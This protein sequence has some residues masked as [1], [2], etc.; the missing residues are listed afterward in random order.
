VLGAGTMGAA[1]A[2]HAANAGLSVDLLDIAPEA[3]TSEEESGGLSLD[4]PA[5]RNRIVNAGFERMRR[6]KPPALLSDGVAAR[7]RLGNFADDLQRL[8]EADW[9]LEAV[10]EDLA[11][12]RALLEGVEAA[13]GDSAIV[14][15]NTSGIPLSRIVE[16]RSPAFRIRFLGTHFFNPP[17]YM[18]LLEVIPTGDTD[19]DLVEYMRSFCQRVLDKRV[20]IAKDTPNFIANRI[21]SYSGMHTV[22]Y[23]LD[24]GYS[25]EEVDALTGPLIGRPKSATFRLTDVVGLDIKLMVAENLYRLVPHDESRDDLEAPEA[26]RRMRAAGLLGNKT[27]SGFYRR[28]ERDGK[29]VFDVL[30]L[31]SLTYRPARQHEDGT[32]AEAARRKDPGERLRFL[33]GKAETDRSAR[34]VRDTLL[35]VLAYAARRI[36]EIADSPA[37]ID[38]AMEWGYGHESGPFRTWDLLGVSRTAEEMEAIGIAVAPWVRAMLSDGNTSFYRQG[39]RVVYGPG[40]QEYEPV[41]EDPPATDLGRPGG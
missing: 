41:R 14:S 19:P 39:G 24:N 22:R 26:L 36:P 12:K 17:R 40:T 27:G 30:D 38:R 25:I 8:Q 32:V 3:L 37:E 2:A 6:T 7:I 31:D 13:C 29:T 18:K 15:S 33:L 35:P 4:S 11:V 1:I 23:A 16:G 9:I 28:A 5:V 10:V 20:V 34:F 21:A